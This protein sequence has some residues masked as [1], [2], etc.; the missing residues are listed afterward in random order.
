LS[1]GSE[2]HAAV[3][4]RYAFLTHDGINGMSGVAVSRYLEWIREGML[5]GLQSDL[6]DFHWVDD[7]YCLC[8][9]RAE[10]RCSYDISISQRKGKMY[11]PMNIPPTLVLPVVLSD[12][13]PLYASK[14]AKRIAIF[15]TMPESTAPRPLY[16]ASG[17][18]LRTIIAPVA[19]NPRGFV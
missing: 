14:L 17:V 15:G 4:C 1:E 6:D 19:I 3:E 10:A 13:Q 5:L 18:S 8:R 7:G 16:R 12:S 11:G 2:R 9:A